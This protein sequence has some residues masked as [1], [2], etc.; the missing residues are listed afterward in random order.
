MHAGETKLIKPVLHFNNLL[1]NVK[2][3]DHVIILGMW[4]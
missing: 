2:V 3:I 1:F 4:G